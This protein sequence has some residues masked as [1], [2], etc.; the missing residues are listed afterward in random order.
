MLILTSLPVTKHAHFL[1]TYALY[2]FR[3][4]QVEIRK[5]SGRKLACSTVYYLPTNSKKCLGYFKKNAIVTSLSI[6][7]GT[8]FLSIY[9]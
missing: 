8:H 4:N 6:T 5:N 1:Q 7:Q 3:Q 9:A 2:I